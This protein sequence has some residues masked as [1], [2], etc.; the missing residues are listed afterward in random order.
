LCR[1]GR[2]SRSLADPIPGGSIDALRP[3]LNLAGEDDFRLI[4]AWLLA[5]MRPH[6]PYPLL[7]LAG[8]PGT[9]KT[10]TATVLRSLFDPH[11][12][13]IRR[14]PK[15]ERDLFITARALRTDSDEALFTV[16]RPVM[17]TSVDDVISRSDLADRAVIVTLTAIPE[18]ERKTKADFNAAIEAARP[19]HN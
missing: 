19:K 6:G 10:S 7:A 8:E 11:V 2:A 5:A 9:S 12:A 16:E 14:P 15:E 1:D 18:A 17:I 3:L 13:G 4:V